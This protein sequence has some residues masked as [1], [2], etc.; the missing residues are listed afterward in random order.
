MKH[1]HVLLENNLIWG[2]P[3]VEM[4]SIH[5]FALQNI[6]KIISITS[7]VVLLRTHGK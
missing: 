7:H 6:K 2:I 4:K 1:V 3:F 5:K